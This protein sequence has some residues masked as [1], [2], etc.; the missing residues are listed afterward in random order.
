MRL[1]FGVRVFIR[2]N[3]LPEAIFHNVGP[4]LVEVNDDRGH[5]EVRTTPRG[6]IA[7]KQEVE[8]GERR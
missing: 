3:P 4:R 7:D 6:P 5:A 1:G 2:H 8:P